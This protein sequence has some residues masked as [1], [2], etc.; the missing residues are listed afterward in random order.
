MKHTEK[1]HSEKHP[2]NSSLFKA[3]NLPLT[4]W[5]GSMVIFLTLMFAIGGSVEN[6]SLF[7]V[8]VLLGDVLIGA[9]AFI[10]FAEKTI[11][12]F[13]TGK[14]G[15]I[16]SLAQSLLGILAL[17]LFFLLTNYLFSDSQKTLKI[18]GEIK[19]CQVNGIVLQITNDECLRVTSAS[20]SSSVPSVPTVTYNQNPESIKKTSSPVLQQDSDPPIHCKIRTE[21]GGGTIPL[22]R[23]ECDLS[24][25]C[26][27]NDKYVF[28]RDKNKCSKDQGENKLYGNVGAPIN[29]VSA[30]I[31]LKNYANSV[32]VKA[33][34]SSA[35]AKFSTCKINCQ[36]ENTNNKDI[37]NFAFG[38]GST[39]EQNNVKLEECIK[40]V[41][42]V[43]TKCQENCGANYS[44]ALYVCVP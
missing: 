17:M 37:C 26:Q 8:L 1:P 19:P 7:T 36:V 14:T 16:N 15:L 20:K 10:I 13:F 5:I 23:S 28:Y 24:V 6:D 40:E 9:C 35:D 30:E 38:V 27:L 42:D 25:C 4:V 3:N 18:A 41:S 44:T 39:Y 22:K 43:Y 11:I 34:I 33:C 12:G 29:A 32:Q 31:I 2:S 21:C